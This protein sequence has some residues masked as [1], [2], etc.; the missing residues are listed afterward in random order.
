MAIKKN[1]GKVDLYNAGYNFFR[2][3]GYDSSILVFTNYTEK[4]PE[5]IFGNY[6]IAKSN[7]AID[8]SGTLGLAVPYYLKAIEIGEKEADKTKVKDKLMGSYQYLIE[9]YYNKMKD[10]ANALIYA[11]KALVLDPNEAQMINNRDFISK[12]DPKAAP[13]KAATNKQA[14]KP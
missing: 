4:F 8:T 5:D 13:K 12:N 10:Q 14:T 1:P 11:D 3:G 9:H 2:G 6:M 7:A